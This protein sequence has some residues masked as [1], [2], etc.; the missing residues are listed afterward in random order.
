MSRIAGIGTDVVEI[1][2]IEAI[3]ERQ[4]ER[5]A[6]RLLAA[7]ELA[8][9][10]EKGG[11]GRYLAKRFATKEAAAKALG[12]GIADGIRFSD[13]E[14]VHDERG[15]PL[16]RFHAAAARRCAELGITGSELSVSDERHYAVAFVVLTGD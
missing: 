5:F 11:S 9:W 8:K 2:R 6:T 16:L 7:G 3:L 1:G 4:G 12:T 13:I 15:K 14:T 10:R